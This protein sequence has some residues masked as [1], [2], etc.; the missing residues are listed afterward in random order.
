MS[1]INTSADCPALSLSVADSPSGLS[2]KGAEFQED[3]IITVE[4][5][6]AKLRCN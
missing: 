1:E 5:L 3:T 4:Q 2:S 6:L